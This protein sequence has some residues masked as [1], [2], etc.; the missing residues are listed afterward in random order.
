VSICPEAVP[1]RVESVDSCAVGATPSNPSTQDSKSDGAPSW[2][3]PVVVVCGALVCGALIGLIV[4]LL[5][6]GKNKPVP[7]DRSSDTAY[8]S[9]PTGYSSENASNYPSAALDRQ[10]N[11]TYAGAAGISEH[12]DSQYTGL[13]ASKMT[14]SDS[15]NQYAVPEMGTQDYVD[16]H[17]TANDDDND[18]DQIAY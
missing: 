18:I 17:L 9:M 11:A 12:S 8:S 2:L 10:P 1:N 16:L 5:K 7:S 14:A 15:S 6:V 3:I 13:R 4:C